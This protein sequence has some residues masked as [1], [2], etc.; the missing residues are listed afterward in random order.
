MKVTIYKDILD[1]TQPYYKDIETVFDM[2]RGGKY[3]KQ[4]LKL[5]QDEANRDKLKKKLPAVVFQGLFNQRNAKGILEGSELSCLDFDKL[6]DP[7]FF[8]DY[9]FNNYDCVYS[10]FISPSGNGVK[11][12][13]R[14]PKVS[15]DKEYKE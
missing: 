14:I 5:R 6:T 4:I 10:A 13:V 8:R 7:V 12:L 9:I 2:I 15:N 11:A 3:S 1:V